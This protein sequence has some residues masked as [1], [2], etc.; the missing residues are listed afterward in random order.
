MICSGCNKDMP[1]LF[2]DDKCGVCFTI[3]Y[4]N[5]KAEL[6]ERDKMIATEQA[7]RDRWKAVAEKVEKNQ[8]AEIARLKEDVDALKA[9][10]NAQK[11]VIKSEL[12]I[13]AK[14]N[15]QIARLKEFA[16]VVIRTECWGYEEQ[17][18][19]ELQELAER[20]GFIVSKIATEEDVDEEAV[21]EVGD[22]IYVFSHVLK[23]GE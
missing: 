2:Y 13:D 23:G 7:N 16:Q 5:L 21:F 9:E 14:L 20:L 22:K 3:E 8:S 18:G 15:W 10:T 11:E 6:A 12:D 17:D 19:F 1:I 4:N